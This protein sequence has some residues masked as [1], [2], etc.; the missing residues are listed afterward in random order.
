V[1]PKSVAMPEFAGAETSSAAVLC[2]CAMVLAWGCQDQPRGAARPDDGAGEVVT[3]AGV[4]ICEKDDVAS[5]KVDPA[6]AEALLPPGLTVYTSEEGEA[7]IAFL[8]QQNCSRVEGSAK[9]TNVD[10]GF[11]WLRVNGPDEIDAVEGATQTMPTYYWYV[12]EAY[13]TDSVARRASLESGMRYLPYQGSI[14][15]PHAA[16]EP[17]SATIQL[18]DTMS[19]SW[20]GSINNPVPAVRVGFNHVLYTETDPAAAIASRLA[21]RPSPFPVFKKRI[22]ALG[23]LVGNS[24]EGTLMAHPQTLIGRVFGARHVA[25]LTG[26]HPLIR[27]E[28]NG[29]LPS[30]LDAPVHEV[31]E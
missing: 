25:S 10:F 26:V 20:R 22:H 3:R 17:H 9:S 21:G 5:I 2:L 27:A 6:R 23:V 19:Y 14:V 1:R 28:F 18:D 16:H 15:G 29:G 30:D 7:R 12:L 11:V 4:K 8:A 13:A 24:S 31:P